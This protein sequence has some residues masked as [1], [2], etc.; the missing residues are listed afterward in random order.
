MALAISTSASTNIWNLSQ[1][2]SCS[3]IDVCILFEAKTLFNDNATERFLYIRFAARLSIHYNFSNLSRINQ[4]IAPCKR[5]A[6]SPQKIIRFQCVGHLR[7][8]Y[9]ALRLPAFA[10]MCSPRRQV[11]CWALVF[12]RFPFLCWHGERSFRC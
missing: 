7:P 10:G 5:K 2:I 4:R 3:G 11:C 12:R 6:F 9:P 1:S 8:V